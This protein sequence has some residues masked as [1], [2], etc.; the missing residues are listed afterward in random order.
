M[1]EKSGVRENTMI[2]LSGD[3][4]ATRERR[5]G[6]NQKVPT[7][8]VNLPYRGFKFSDFDGGMHVPGLVNWPGKIPA[9][10]VSDELVLI[11]DVLPT[12]AN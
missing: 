2:V 5:A 6:L 7:A 1:L 4:G 9:G 3:N 10:Q 12:F 8:G 11:T